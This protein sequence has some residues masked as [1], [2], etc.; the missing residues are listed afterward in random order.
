MIKVGT[1]VYTNLYNYGQGIVVAIHG[2]QQPD[3]IRHMGGG[4]VAM[5][6]SAHFDI[7]FADGR[8]AMKLPESILHGVQWNILDNSPASAVEI[9]QA[10]AKAEEYQQEAKQQAE[11]KATAAQDAREALRVNPEFDHLIQVDDR[12]CPA[13]EVAKNV[14]RHLKK[15]FPGVKFSVR[16]DI[17]SINVSYSDEALD[18]QAIEEK[19]DLFQEGYFNGMEDIY[20]RS[21]S[22]FN[23]VFGGVKFVFVSFRRK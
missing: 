15:H 19:A 23:G 8:S 11:A 1:H 18:H 12:Y 4:V 6:G 13:K 2:E 7:V 9:E 5:G 10:K 3:T 14:R 16:T 22:P 17:N 21:N 20:E